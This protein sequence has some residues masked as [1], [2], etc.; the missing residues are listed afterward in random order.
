[1]I[2]FAKSGI[3]EVR[4]IPTHAADIRLK[5]VAKFSQVVPKASEP[6]PLFGPELRGHPPS[7]LGN[8]GEMLFERMS[9]A[10]IRR[11]N[12][13]DGFQLMPGGDSFVLHRTP[14]LWSIRTG[15]TYMNRDDAPPKALIGA[16]GRAA[17]S[18]RRSP[19]YPSIATRVLGLRIL[20]RLSSS[21]KTLRLRTYCNVQYNPAESNS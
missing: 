6:A 20:F 8:S 5:V 19:L 21:E 18:S 3:D 15:D 14:T 12:M 1:M 16:S 10:Q 17:L 11:E 7:H 4:F 2:D 13:S 9:D